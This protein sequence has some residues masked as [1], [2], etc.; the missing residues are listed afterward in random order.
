MNGLVEG[1]TGV[2]EGYDPLLVVELCLSALTPDIP[3]VG[4]DEGRQALCG[5][6]EPLRLLLEVDDLFHVAD[7]SHVLRGVMVQYEPEVRSRE[8]EAEEDDSAEE[9]EEEEV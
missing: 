9:G 4:A 2:D 6:G 5:D 8:A 7:D 1:L 3:L